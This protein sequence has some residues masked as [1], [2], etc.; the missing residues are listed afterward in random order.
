MTSESSKVKFLW[1]LIFAKTGED[2]CST[3]SSAQNVTDPSVDISQG[4]VYH[5]NTRALTTTNSFHTTR[6][7]SDFESRLT[8]NESTK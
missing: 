1:S 4:H 2:V 8:R 7:N 3:Q 6:N 5:R